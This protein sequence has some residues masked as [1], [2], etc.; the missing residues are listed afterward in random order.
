MPL[1]ELHL[2]SS[3]I[4]FSQGLGALAELQSVLV[5]FCHGSITE[6]DKPCTGSSS[7]YISACG[8]V[9]MLFHLHGVVSLLSTPLNMPA[10]L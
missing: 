1:L 6:H 3:A 8:F 10:K 9:G 7:S 5:G 2:R 4:R